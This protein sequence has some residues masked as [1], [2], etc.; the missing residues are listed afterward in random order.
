MPDTH[1]TLIWFWRDDAK[2]L[3]AWFARNITLYSDCELVYAKLESDAVKNIRC[4]GLKS[5]KR[6]NRDYG[7]EKNKYG[8]LVT[9]RVKGDKING[10]AK[11][12]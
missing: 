5:Q 4:R 10:N 8:F 6:I 1:T 3:K 2:A 12:V 11:A 7:K 9:W